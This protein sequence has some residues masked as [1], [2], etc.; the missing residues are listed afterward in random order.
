M[1]REKEGYRDQLEMIRD[2][3]PD[4]DLLS[5]CDVAAFCG[6]SLST[7]HRRFKTAN[8]LGNGRGRRITRAELA[9]NLC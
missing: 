5:P 9:R 4:R 7:V 3:F 1:A 6:C 2:A 8:W